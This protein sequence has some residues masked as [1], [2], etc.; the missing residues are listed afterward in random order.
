MLVR[1]DIFIRVSNC[2]E[3]ISNVQVVL[4]LRCCSRMSVTDYMVTV[5]TR[6]FHII[7]RNAATRRLSAFNT[8]SVRGSQRV[9]IFQVKL[10]P[11]VSKIL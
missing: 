5:Y 10:G 6:L 11:G 4:V 9:P 1:L 7:H 3:G 2:R 8:E